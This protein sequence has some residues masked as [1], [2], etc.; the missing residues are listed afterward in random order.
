MT[1]LSASGPR[2]TDDA[3][4]GGGLR[5]LQPEAGYR[6]GIDAVLLAA[7]APVGASRKELV[8]DVGAGVGVVG[9]AVAH[10][11]ANAHVTLIERE[12]LLADLARQN[13]FRNN[14]RYTR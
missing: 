9:L 2:L 3:F 14:L 10:R 7:A 1:K 5:I 11:A 13:I 4:L 12:P 6:A 8:L